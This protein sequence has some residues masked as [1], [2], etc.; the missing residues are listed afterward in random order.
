MVVEF[1]GLVL[2]NYRLLVMMRLDLE[3]IE[4]CIAA[5]GVPVQE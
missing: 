4:N 1:A 5:S 3:S 2:T